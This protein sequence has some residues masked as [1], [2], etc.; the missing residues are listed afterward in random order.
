[1]VAFRD[2]RRAMRARRE[3]ILHPGLPQI[4]PRPRKNLLC[5]FQILARGTYLCRVTYFLL[6][7]LRC[8]RS[9]GR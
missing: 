2:S 3:P 7:R 4:A 1:M 6:A 9:A 5:S 8:R